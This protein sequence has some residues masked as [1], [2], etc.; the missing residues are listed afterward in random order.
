MALGLHVRVEDGPE[1]DP[2]EPTSD[3]EAEWELVGH[4]E[5]PGGSRE[6]ELATAPPSEPS[7]VRARNRVRP[8]GDQSSPEIFKSVYAGA[9]RAA[10]KGGDVALAPS[11]QQEDE[12]Q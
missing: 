8:Q 7:V 4:S 2:A 5:S 3:S 11:L 10:Q 6:K 1:Q 9:Q 12:V